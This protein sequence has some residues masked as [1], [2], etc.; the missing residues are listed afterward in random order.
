MTYEENY[1]FYSEKPGGKTLDVGRSL[2]EEDNI[3][4]EIECWGKDYRPIHLV[5]DI[6]LVNTVIF[7]YVFWPG[8]GLDAFFL[9]QGVVVE[10]CEHGNKTLGFLKVVNFL[11]T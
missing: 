8:S 4:M 5:Q 3:K 7:V 11:T 9:G 6:N 10:S 2:G 1:T